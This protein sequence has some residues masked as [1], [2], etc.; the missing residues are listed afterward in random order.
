MSG[1]Y[2][3]FRKQTP[4]VAG[5]IFVGLMACSSPE[6]AGGTTVETTNGVFVQVETSSLGLQGSVQGFALRLG[7]APAERLCVLSEGDT[8]VYAVLDSQVWVRLD[9]MDTHSV[10]DFQMWPDLQSVCPVP[11][12][13][14]VFASPDT[15]WWVQKDWGGERFDGASQHF[16]LGDVPGWPASYTLS[17]EFVLDSGVVAGEVITVGNGVGFRVDHLGDR[18]G[19]Y[20][21][22]SY[23][24]TTNWTVL[25]AQLPLSEPTWVRIDMVV[26]SAK[27]T[28]ALY[29]DGELW[30]ETLL[31]GALTYDKLGQTIHVGVHATGD[32]GFFRG[33]LGWV[34]VAA[35]ARSADWIRLSARQ[36]RSG[37]GWLAQEIPF[38]GD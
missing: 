12:S 6:H 27:N 4:W 36:G 29:H 17:A 30:T 11:D 9:S 21:Y 5:L 28:L 13:T 25:G 10:W 3:Q 18:L 24:G 32:E 38:S 23:A 8:L 15:A 31:M 7:Q 33:Y 16:S 22:A 34:S 1:F 14:A 20:S 35:T 26:D 19:L 37:T 2:F